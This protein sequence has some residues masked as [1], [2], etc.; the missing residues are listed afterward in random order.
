MDSEFMSSS[1]RVGSTTHT[2]LDEFLG[3]GTGL[4]DCCVAEQCRVKV[5]CMIAVIGLLLNEWD[6]YWRNGIAGY[7]YNK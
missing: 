1:E 3:M 5:A 6:R 4:D 7:T 2:G